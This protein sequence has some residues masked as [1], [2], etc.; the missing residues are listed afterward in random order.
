[1]VAGLKLLPGLKRKL[2]DDIQEDKMETSDAIQSVCHSSN[3]SIAS[4]RRL[5]DQGY[6]IN[7]GSA[8]H[9]RTNCSRGSSKC[10]CAVEGCLSKGFAGLLS[11]RSLL[12]CDQERVCRRI[13]YA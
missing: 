6:S 2:P 7:D 10:P 12:Q 13:S 8:E 5:I 11:S 1:M 3:T 4:K 9:A